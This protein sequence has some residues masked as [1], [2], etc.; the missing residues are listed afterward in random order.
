MYATDY[1]LHIEN[2]IRKKITRV[3]LPPR[4][5]FFLSQEDLFSKVHTLYS[6]SQK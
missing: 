5:F 6:I 2:T 1:I 3:L 4:L